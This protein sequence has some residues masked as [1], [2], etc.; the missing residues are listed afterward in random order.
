[1]AVTL[2]QIKELREVTG[3][4]MMACKKAMEEADGDL[5]KAIDTLR[6][7]GEAKAIERG[8][9]STSQGTVASYIHGNGKLGVIV[10]I[11]CETDFVAKN[12]EFQNLAKDIA[13]HIAA[14][15]PLV[16]SPDDVS[17]ELVEKEREIWHQQLKNE[18]KNDKMIEMILTGKEKKF[19]EENALLKQV[20]VKDPEK[21]IEGLLVHAITKM[22]EN[23]KI[24][25]FARFSV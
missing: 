22:G 10:Q 15:N 4:S 7:K 13:M 5:N 19:R 9:R 8:E 3:S 23:I 16:L 11:G 21:T 24:V 18:G 2:E 12:E 20:F 14:M 25:R 17:H 6:K 1:M